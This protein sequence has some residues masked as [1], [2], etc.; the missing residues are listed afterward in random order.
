[1]SATFFTRTSKRVHLRSE[2]LYV[3]LDLSADGIISIRGCVHDLQQGAT[4][5]SKHRSAKHRG[6]PC[7]ERLVMARME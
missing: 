3:L 7:G 6:L 1:M 2:P 5:R 4:L